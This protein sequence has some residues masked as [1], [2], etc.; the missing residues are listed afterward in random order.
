MSTDRKKPQPLLTVKEAAEILK[1]CEKSVRRF[2]ER[3]EL[4]ASK[5]G[6]LVRID[7]DDLVD[8]IRDHRSQ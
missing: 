6:G 5:L 3:R 8:F 1:M 2:I 4:R 7:P